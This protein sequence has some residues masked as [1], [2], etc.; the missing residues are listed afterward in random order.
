VSQYTVGTLPIG[1]QDLIVR[2]RYAQK[3]EDARADLQGRGFLGFAAHTEMMRTVSAPSEFSVETTYIFD[4]RSREP[5]TG[6]Y[7]NA[8][9]PSDIEEVRS[10]GATLSASVVHI[11]SRAVVPA[12]APG[13]AF[14][15]E[16]LRTEYTAELN[17]E[18]INQKVVRN[19]GRWVTAIDDFGNPKEVYQGVPDPAYEGAGIPCKLDAVEGCKYVQ[20]VYAHEVD[21]N[22]D[23]PGFRDLPIGLSETFLKARS[24]RPWNN[25]SPWGPNLDS[26][27]SIRTTAYE[28]YDNGDLHKT[29]IEPGPNDPVGDL[30]TVHRETELVRDRFGNVTQR[31][32]TAGLA[33]LPSE[34]NVRTED[35][36]YSVS[37]RSPGWYPTSLKNAKGQ[38]TQLIYD[39]RFGMVGRAISPMN[40]VTESYYDD[41]GRLV[42]SLSHPLI[43]HRTIRV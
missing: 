7:F 24:S 40:A 25:P 12:N 32:D 23:K 9:V 31:I 19:F 26:V 36:I 6:M 33:S 41:F 29:I 27:S 22:F 38:E 5:S 42:A 17:L 2:R 21:D 16:T 11:E 18:T 28:Y 15:S 14:R 39:E 3:Y 20:T 30:D 43:K 37:G 1:T 4:N 8:L 34:A 10:D 35:I 13:T